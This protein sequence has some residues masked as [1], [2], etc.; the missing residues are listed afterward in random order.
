LK[1]WFGAGRSDVAPSNLGA[2]SIEVCSD[3]A[4]GAFE[5]SSEVGAEKLQGDVVIR[6][7]CIAFGFLVVDKGY[8]HRRIFPGFVPRRL[9]D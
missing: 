8:G 7:V 2:D 6:I 5:Y 1:G 3:V 9:S 4:D